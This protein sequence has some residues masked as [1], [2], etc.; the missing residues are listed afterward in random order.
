MHWSKSLGAMHHLDGLKKGFQITVADRGTWAEL[1]VFLPGQGFNA[2]V[3]V[4]ESVA[5]AQRAGEE[6]AHALD[7]FEQVAA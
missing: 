6:R 2:H 4:C 5:H 1:L 3:E 7:A